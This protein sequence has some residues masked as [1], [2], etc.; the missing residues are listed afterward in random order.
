MSEV[1]AIESQGRTAMNAQNDLEINLSDLVAVTD[2]MINV[3]S[4]DMVG[5]DVNSCGGILWR[6]AIEA[7]KAFYEMCEFRAKERQGGAI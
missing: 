3:Q 2:L 7:Q 4:V 1:V 5:S 6:M